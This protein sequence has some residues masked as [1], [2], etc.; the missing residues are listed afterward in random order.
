MKQILPKKLKSW[1]DD[2]S[3]KTPV[4]IDIRSEEEFSFCS[5]PGSLS[6]PEDQILDQLSFLKKEEPIV[7]V[8]HGFDRSPSVALLLERHGFLDVSVLVGGIDAWSL[9]VDQSLPRYGK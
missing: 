3:R 8:C 5:I 2:S 4:L 6:I 1:L 7:V 9:R